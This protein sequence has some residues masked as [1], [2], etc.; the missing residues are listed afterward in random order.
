M[1]VTT[2]DGATRT[3]D[4]APVDAYRLMVEA[5]AAA[6]RGED[7]W[8]PGLDHS[9]D[10][11][12]TSD[13]VRARAAGESAPPATAIPSAAPCRVEARVLAAVITTLRTRAR[14]RVRRLRLSARAADGPGMEEAPDCVVEGLAPAWGPSWVR[15][16]RFEVCQDP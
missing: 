7:A 9:A 2:P 15:T 14:T 12:R 8:L 11:A 13:A 6:V 4:F 1:T 10:V 5:V 3:E 16:A